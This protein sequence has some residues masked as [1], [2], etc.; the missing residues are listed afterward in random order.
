M[1]RFQQ[2]I[3][4]IEQFVSIAET[5]HGCLDTDVVLI[6]YIVHRDNFTPTHT[7]VLGQL[8]QWPAEQSFPLPPTLWVQPRKGELSCMGSTW[9]YAFH[10]QGVSFMR[11]SDQLDVSIEY[12]AQGEL[13]IDAYNVA[14]Y[15]SVAAPD[16]VPMHNQLFAQCIKEHILISQPARFGSDSDTFV[17]SRLDA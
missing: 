11:T 13:G 12:T 10:G 7:T 3:H 2:Y 17:F 6:P 8:R 1:D 16:L 14:S 9:E 4:E 5:L 15:L